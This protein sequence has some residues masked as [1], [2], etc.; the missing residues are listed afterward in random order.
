MNH[1]TELGLYPEKNKEPLEGSTEGSSRITFRAITLAAA[2]RTGCSSDKADSA[3]RLL[4]ASPREQTDKTITWIHA[5][6]TG[7]GRKGLFDFLSDCL[8]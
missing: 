6:P 4:R 1:I 3:R 2:S 7:G 5:Y 8:T